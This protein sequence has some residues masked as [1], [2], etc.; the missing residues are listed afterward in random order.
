MKYIPVQAHASDGL[1]G[2][3][4]ASTSCG[5]TSSFGTV[6]TGR[7]ASLKFDRNYWSKSF[8][9]YKQSQQKQKPSNTV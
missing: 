8:S 6:T 5:F 2:S 1:R 4:P 9:K 7:H 3:L